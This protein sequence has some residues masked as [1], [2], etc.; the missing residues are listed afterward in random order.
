MGQKMLSAAT[1]LK[2]QEEL[3]LK[4]KTKPKCIFHNTSQNGNQTALWKME[5]GFRITTKFEDGT[6]VRKDMTV[7]EVHLMLIQRTK[8]PKEE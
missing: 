5:G 8:K 4:E 1:R 3:P 6:I 2:G 7:G